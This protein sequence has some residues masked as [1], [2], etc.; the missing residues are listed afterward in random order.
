[1]KR[2]LKIL[3]LIHTTTVLQMA[4]DMDMEDE[5]ETGVATLHRIFKS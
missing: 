2:D 5:R 3:R 4:V 1:M